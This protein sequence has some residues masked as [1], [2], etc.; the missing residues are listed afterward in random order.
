MIEHLDFPDQTFNVVVNTIMMHHLPGDLKRRGLSEI[1]RV[2]KPGGRLVIADFSFTRR[3]ERQDSF[4]RLGAD[5]RDNQELAALV[6]D[7][8]L[9]EATTE[10]TRFPRVPAHPEVS[11]VVFVSAHKR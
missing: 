5:E 9:I 11:G 1:V 4:G 7:A 8:G 2:L 10:E 6:Q 3:D